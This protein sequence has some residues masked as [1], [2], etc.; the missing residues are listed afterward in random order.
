[1]LIQINNL[2]KVYG[3]GETLVNALHNINLSVQKGEFVAVVGSSGCGKST[4]LHMI[5]AMASPDK[6]E[7]LLEGESLQKLGSRRLTNIR[8][9]KMG[10]IFQTFNLIPTLT[11][12]ENVM[13]PMKLSR[14]PRKT[15]R[16]KSL[17][18]LTKLGLQ[19][20]LRHVPS[21]LSGGQKQRV[22]IARALANN[23]SIILADEPTGNLDSA[24]GE[25]IMELLQTLN[26]EGH[27]IILVTHDLKLAARAG[28]IIHMK[29]GEFTAGVEE[30]QCCMP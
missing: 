24:N 13:L 2:S 19:D 15:A 22:A 27:T 9:N 7:I 30:W 20:R 12:F 4:L 29:D 26:R 3:S 16:E 28:R 10:F 18:L 25:V 14:I 23:P 1:M 21:Q 8:L 6:G 5:G 11:A 17:Q